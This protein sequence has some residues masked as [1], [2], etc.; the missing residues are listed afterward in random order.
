MRLAIAS[1]VLALPALSAIADARP[2]TAG[3]TAGVVQSK[4]DA[5]SGLD[6][7]HTIG[8]FGRLGFSPKVA[9]QLEVSRIETDDDSSVNIRSATALLVVDLGSKGHLVPI[10]VAGVGLDDASD[11]YGNSQGAHHIEGGLGLEYRAAGGISIGFDVRMGGR[12][13]HDDDSV[14]P[15][16]GGIG[17]STKPTPTTPTTLA[18]APSTLREGEY[19]TARLTLGIQF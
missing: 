12:S 9:G 13:L 14:R 2:I 16:S 1:A 19:R 17:S 15:L 11:P 4:Q 8:L 7:S 18:Y 10:L 5:D 3:L 6:A